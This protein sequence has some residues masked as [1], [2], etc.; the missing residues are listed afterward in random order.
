LYSAHH[1]DDVARLV[2]EIGQEK[3]P[4][5]DADTARIAARG[6]NIPIAA[7]YV[8]AKLETKGF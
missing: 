5:S 2:R 8:K 1:F 3:P 6:L 7:H 4:M